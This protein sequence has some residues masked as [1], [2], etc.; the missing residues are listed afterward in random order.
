MEVYL[1]QYL[2]KIFLAYLDT[3]TMDTGIRGTQHSSTRAVGQSSRT[4]VRNSNTGA[5]ME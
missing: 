3:A 4:Q 1:L 5:S 2:A